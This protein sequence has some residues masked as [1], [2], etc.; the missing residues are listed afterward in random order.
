[1]SSRTALA[2]RRVSFEDAFNRRT[3]PI[4]EPRWRDRAAGYAFMDELH[5]NGGDDIELD[6][7]PRGQT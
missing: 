7:F 3:E 4:G 2:R 6:A 5:E 1:M